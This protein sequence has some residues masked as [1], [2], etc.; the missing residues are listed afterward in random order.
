MKKILIAAAVLTVFGA[1]DAVSQTT[2]DANLSGTVQQT[3][4]ISLT[5]ASVTFPA[6]DAAAFDAG[7]T[8]VAGGTLTHKGNVAHS[9]SIA[10]AAT[11][12][13]AAEVDG[14]TGVAR[15]DKPV[16]DVSVSTDGSN[17]TA[18]TS[19]TGAPVVPS[20]A[21]G[22]H[23]KTLNYRMGLDWAQDTPGI[24]SLDVTYTI[25]AN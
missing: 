23:E 4:A 18:V 24:Y 1:Q 10:T 11:N 8:Q 9:V 19:V 14:N 6:A 15:Q 20:A 5:N 13:T 2:A 16:G 22:E 12:M 3:L 17:F 21:A 25:A 7:Y